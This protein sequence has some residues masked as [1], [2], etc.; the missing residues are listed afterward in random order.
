MSENRF[1]RLRKKHEVLVIEDEV[2]DVSLLQ[3]AVERAAIPVHLNFVAT[4]E[5]ALQYLNDVPDQHKVPDLILLDLKLPDMQGV[6]VIQAIRSHTRL[7]ILPIVV[8]SALEAPTEIVAAYR[9]G[10]NCFIKKPHGSQNFMQAIEAMFDFWL[11]FV[12]L[13]QSGLE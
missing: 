4:G 3:E 5:A 12:K 8:L 1:E 2:S 10:C 13:P 9:S 7:C 11:N 6:D